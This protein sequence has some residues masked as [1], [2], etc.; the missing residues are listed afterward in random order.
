MV[1]GGL[2]VDV[3]VEGRQSRTGASKESGWG[4]A[5]PVPLLADLHL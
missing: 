4:W 5:D 3:P 2:L 1:G